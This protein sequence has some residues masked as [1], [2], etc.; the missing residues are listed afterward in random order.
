MVRPLLSCLLHYTVKPVRNDH[1]GD[2]VH[3]GLC[4][5]VVLIQR[6]SSN[7]EV[8]HGAAYSGH[9]RQVVLIQRCSS[10]TE[11]AHGAAYS[12]WSL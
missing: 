5:Q 3:D 7:T 6:C 2:Q 9:Y 10:N 12:A 8:A 4:R 1:S 11:V